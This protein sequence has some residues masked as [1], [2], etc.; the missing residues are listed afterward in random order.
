MLLRKIVVVFTTLICA[1]NIVICLMLN[2]YIV[3]YCIVLYF[4]Q[5]INYICSIVKDISS[6]I[7]GAKLLREE[8]HMQTK[9]S[10][11]DCCCC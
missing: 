11:S 5:E 3:L 9:K 2:K 8:K 6:L 1:I 7:P 4:E 10:R